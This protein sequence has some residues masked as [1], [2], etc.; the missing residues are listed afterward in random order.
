MP[1]RALDDARDLA[2]GLAADER[3]ELAHELLTSLDG[4]ADSDAASAWEAEIER[5]LDA[6]QSG[7]ATTMTAEDALAKIDRR[8]GR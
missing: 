2:L 3:A 5:R 7:Q 4:P 1:S 8:L 6:L